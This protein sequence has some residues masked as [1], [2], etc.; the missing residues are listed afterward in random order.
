LTIEKLSAVLAVP[1]TGCGGPGKIGFVPSISLGRPGLPKSTPE[2]LAVG[3][4]YK[5][6]VSPLLIS[7]ENWRLLLNLR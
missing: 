4:D 2:T 5:S 1:S 7:P 6:F 3:A